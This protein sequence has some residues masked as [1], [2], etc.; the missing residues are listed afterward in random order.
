MM[1]LCA[2]ALAQSSGLIIIRDTEIEN[3]IREWA[4]PI[5]K[6]ADMDPDTVKIILVQDDAVNAFVA[7]GSNIFFY[8]GLLTR[9]E[10]AG[11]I[12]GVLA[13]ELGHIKG[14][15]L[16]AGRKAMERASYESI[17][18][19]ILGV[20]AAIA[21]GD[22]NAAAAIGT[23]GA[24]MAQR[25]YLANSRVFESS[26]DQAALTFMQDAHMSPDGLIS[27]LGKLE[28]ED[29]LPYDQQSEY[30]RSHPI[31]RDRIEALNTRAAGSPYKDTPYPKEWDEQQAR[32]KAKLVGFINPAQVAWDYSDRDTSLPAQYARAIA[33]YRTNKV[34]Q[35][36]KDVDGLLA[37]EPQNPYFL[38][39]KGQMLMDFGRVR[40]SIP[41]YQKSVDILGD[42][43]LIR[44][45]LGHAQLESANGNPEQIRVAITQLERSLK[46][47]PRSTK[48]HRLLATAYGQLGDENE[49]KLHLAEEAVLQRKISYAK[50]L[51]ESVKASSPQGSRAWIQAQDL[52]MHIDTLDIDEDIDE[53]N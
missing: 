3:Q 9:A 28:S 2:P 38:E 4:L 32:M 33:A 20:G 26:A 47:E 52:E 17:L 11:E 7:G 31:T 34:E 5:F 12:V 41:Y 15:H 23:G 13:H 42:A 21:T 18:G 49:A 43:P 1:A 6:A 14:G 29:M 35:S 24:S 22:G 30:M 46:S 25:R 51:V 40:E 27:F 37:L 53:D 48:I 36:L 19:M 10:N 50:K 45:S 39:L 44:M 16:I 8:T